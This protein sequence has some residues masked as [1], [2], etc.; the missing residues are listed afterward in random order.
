MSQVGSQQCKSLKINS[1]RKIVIFSIFF[2]N[3][4]FT[5][6][7]DKGNPLQ[8][9]AAREGINTQMVTKEMML[10]ASKNFPIDSFYSKSEM[11]LLNAFYDKII[12]ANVYSSSEKESSKKLY[13]FA[14]DLMQ[15]F[16][17]EKQGGSESDKE[18]DFSYSF[19]H[20]IKKKGNQ[21]PEFIMITRVGDAYTTV[22]QVFMND[23][24]I[25]DIRQLELTD[26]LK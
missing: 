1:M 9:Y 6:A 17:Y 12:S 3:I 4:I 21:V 25:E 8:E 15:T 10:D 23:F 26:Q 14:N 19:L 11:S 7:Q 5:N 24:T 20:Y 13:L 18:R 22:M 16:S 2:S